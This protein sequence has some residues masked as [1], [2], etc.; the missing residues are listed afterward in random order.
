MLLLLDN[1]E[2]LLP[3]AALVAQLLAGCP[4]LKVLC[5]SREALR[6]RAERLFAVPPMRLPSEGQRLAGDR[7]V[8]DGAAVRRAGVGGSPRFRA[9]RGN[10]EAVAEI[11][12]RLD[13]LPLAIELAAAHVRALTPQALLAAL[14]NRLDL[15][16]EGPRDL[17]ARQQTLRG[18]IDWSHELLGERGAARVP[19][20]VGVP[21]RLHAGGRRGG[22]PPGPEGVN[23]LNEPCLA[24]REEPPQV[25]PTSTGSPATGCWRRSANTPGNAWR[26]AAELGQRRSRGSPPISCDSPN[27]RSRS[28]TVRSRSCGSTGSKPSTTTSAPR[29]PGCATRAAFEDALRLAG[30][31]GWFWFRRGRFSEG[32]HWLEE[33]R[34]LAGEAVPP[35]PRAKAA[36]YLGWMKLCVGS[37]FWGNPE[38][39]EYFGESLRLWRESGNR[40]GIALS[41]VWLGWKTGDIEGADGWALADDSVAVARETGDPWALAWCLKIAYSNLR[42]PGQG[43]ERQAG[44]ARGSHRPARSTEDPFLLCQTL[45]GMGNVFAWVGELA[46]AE[47][48]YP[49][50]LSLARQID[51]TWSI[52]D[53]MN[54]LADVYLGLGQTPKSKELFREGLRLAAD[55]S[56][57]AYLVWFIGG[58]YG[59]AK[60]EGQAQAGSAPGRRVGIDPEPRPALTTRISA[61]GLAWTRRSPERNGRP[62]RP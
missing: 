28:C 53:S 26:K 4:R 48:W 9:E 22:V 37:A 57:R 7:A 47:P 56:A 10:V 13:G 60:Q 8:R 17:P 42:S 18:E 27:G 2:H 16:Q 35:G 58:L 25:R 38:G 36:Y 21:G 34:S 33:L 23:I 49:E 3:A 45:T 24:G 43:P 11:C 15:L 59:V 5:T 29:S 52:L 14:G 55:L 44:R 30:A 61:R 12:M 50:A 40:R 31:L 1:F 62:G 46:A 51:D 6:L 32:Q 19:A 41:Q 54:C 20:A 39:K